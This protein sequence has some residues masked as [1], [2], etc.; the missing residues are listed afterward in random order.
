VCCFCQDMF[1]LCWNYDG[2]YACTPDQ[3]KILDSDWMDPST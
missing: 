2:M 3:A 1:T